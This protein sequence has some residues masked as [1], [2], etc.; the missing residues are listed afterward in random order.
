MTTST[1]ACDFKFRSGIA[2]ITFYNTCRV[3]ISLLYPSFARPQPTESEH[4]EQR[5][6]SP[7]RRATRPQPHRLN[8]FH[9]FPKRRDRERGEERERERERASSF[10]TECALLRQ[11]SFWRALRCG[12]TIRSAAI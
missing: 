2:E 6:E 4:R 10:L 12:I 5:A 1:A 9:P 8:P 3:G 11:D 7:T